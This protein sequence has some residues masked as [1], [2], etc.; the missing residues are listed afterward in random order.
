MVTV[1]LRAVKEAKRIC[2]FTHLFNTYLL[3]IWICQTLCQVLAKED[4]VTPEAAEDA[5]SR[6]DHSPWAPDT[7]LIHLPVSTLPVPYRGHF[8]M[9]DQSSGLHLGMILPFTLPTPHTSISPQRHLAMSGGVLV[10]STWR[11]GMLL[12]SSG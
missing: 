6:A 10:V 3:G 7:N 5:P 11:G 1:G 12:E 4:P 9:N 8:I 2:S